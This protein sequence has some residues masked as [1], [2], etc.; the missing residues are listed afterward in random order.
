MD[1]IRGL[2]DAGRE[3]YRSA[4]RVWN[5]VGHRT[6]VCLKRIHGRLDGG[7]VIVG[8][9]AHGSPPLRINLLDMGSLRVTGVTAENNR[10]IPGE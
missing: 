10:S 6:A 1:G 4:D 8:I 3:V 5:A 9:I 2:V 7:G